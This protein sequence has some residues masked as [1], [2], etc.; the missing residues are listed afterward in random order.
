VGARLDDDKGAS[1]GSAYVFERQV[2]GI[3]TQAAKLVAKDGAASDYF[4]YSVAISGK[5]V[6]VGAY[7]DDDKGASLGSAY[8]YERQANGTWTQA[9]KLVAKNGAAGDDFGRSVAISGDRIVVGAYGDDDKGSNSGSA[10]VYERQKDGTWSQ[11]SKLVAKDGAANDR[12]GASVSISSDR[13]LVGTWGDDDKGNASGS[14]YV[15]ERQVDGTWTQAAKLVAK[16]GAASDNFGVSV[17]ISGERVVVSA[18]YDDD[19]GNASGSAYAFEMDS[20]ACEAADTCSCKPGFTGKNCDVFDCAG[21]KCDDGNPCTTDSCDKVKGCQTTAVKDQT[22]CS[23]D[24]SKLCIAAKCIT[25][26]QCPKTCSSLGTKQSYAQAAKLLA[27]DGAASD[28]FGA[29]VAISGDRMV[30][31]APYDDDK[32]NASGSAYVYERQK[33]GSWAQ[34]AKLLAKDGAEK[35][36]FGFSV[37]ISGDRI[38]VGARLDDDKGSSSG[39]AYVYERQANGTW[40]QAAKLRAK[41]G[42]ANDFFGY[43]VAISGDRLVVGANGDDDKG[44]GSGSAYVY[45]LQAKGAWTQTAKLLAKDG[46][47]SD[48]FGQAVAIS[49]SRVVVGAN[50][51]DDKGSNSGSAYV[52]E[53]QDSGIWTQAAKLV[54]KDGAASDYFGR[55]VAISG[56]RVVAG[57]RY[58]DDKGFNS[59][60]AYV[61]ERQKNGSW[62]Q[63]AKLLAKDGAASD[64]FGYSVSISGGRIVV[65]AYLDDDK[66][67][68]SGSAYVFERQDSGIWTQAAKL[69][70]KDG[71][72]SDYFGQ[73]VAISGDRVVVGATADDDKGS[74]SGSAYPFDINPICTNSTTCACKTGYAGTDCGVVVKP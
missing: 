2:N 74:S 19:K 7:G 73:S 62:T 70:A 50:G 13:A 42:A 16:D 35:D 65:G 24:G 33:D 58:D 44:I 25:V 3:W 10:Y 52:Y 22:S 12:F 8:V 5:R 69:V 29:S 4:G 14:A 34:A 17:A 38:V 61:Y 20:F 48:V 64:Y 67:S 47:A 6:V 28:R 23:Q 26:T 71:A 60:S 41:D 63:A 18:P 46:A 51:D 40:T 39:S 57:A 56:D 32:G 9:T 21:T 1:S 54:A 27:K 49:G 15:Y 11:V 45:E 36:N 53:R 37:A 68:N 30:V 72:A 59:G 31:S 66:G 43:S 55:S